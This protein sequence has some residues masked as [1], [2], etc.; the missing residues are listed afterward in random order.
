MALLQQS[1][2]QNPA[3]TPDR[4]APVTGAGDK[5][6]AGK[7]QFEEA[8]IRPCDPDSVPA[9]PPGGRGG[10]ANS[11]QMTPGRTHVLCM[12][13]ATIIRHAYGYGPADLDFLDPGGRDSSL[14]LNAVYGLGVEDGVRVR[15][16]PD[17]VHSERG[18]G[19]TRWRMV[20]QM[21]RCR[22][23]A[24]GIA[25]APVPVEGAHRGGASSRVHAH[26]GQR[27]SEDQTCGAWRLRAATGP[28]ARSASVAASAAVF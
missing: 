5:A 21:P 14:N 2:P 15:R 24:A 28:D 17:W 6:G 16:G 19:S 12:T 26:D 10:G 3:Q 23:D 7:P 22:P 25:G 27:R 8:S 4:P 9:A 11:F 20:W 18:P 13:L 1:A